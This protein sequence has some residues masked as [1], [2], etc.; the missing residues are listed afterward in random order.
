MPELTAP[1]QPTLTRYFGVLGIAVMCVGAV[2]MGQVIRTQTT[3][4]L[5]HVAEQNNRDLTTALA[6]SLWPSYSAFARNAGKLDAA[7]IR[8]DPQT[9]WLESQI[10]VL[11][12]GTRVMKVKL[13][14]LGGGNRLLE[15]ALANW[16]QLS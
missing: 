5:H 9:R 1:K 14:D 10:R 11:M 16:F 13:Y 7:E 4:Q 15:R 3:D 2:V 12:E 6:N 8:A